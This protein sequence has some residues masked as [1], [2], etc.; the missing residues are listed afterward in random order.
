M[1]K[2]GTTS[3]AP[4]FSEVVEGLLALLLSVSV[5]CP[6]GA[7][8]K[9]F[10]DGNTGLSVAEGNCVVERRGGEQP[11]AK[12]Q[13]INKTM[14]NSIRPDAL[15]STPVLWRSQDRKASRNGGATIPRPI[16]GQ[17]SE[18]NDRNASG[19]WR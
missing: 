18:Q 1:R 5:L 8:G 9:S 7:T 4:C 3:N 10:P 13:S 14:L 15:A 6:A 19:G 17:S 2:R 11:E 12:D 16:P